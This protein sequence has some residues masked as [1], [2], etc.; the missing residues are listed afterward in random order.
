VLCGERQQQTMNNPS[1][2]CA[3]ILV[4]PKA[5]EPA[6]FVN[7]GSVLLP[8]E[9]SFCWMQIG[10]PLGRQSLEWRATIVDFAI[11]YY[12]QASYC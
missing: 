5:T 3:G 2:N 8:N 6:P 12:A 7:P 10:V 4:F 9:K 11:L 1:R